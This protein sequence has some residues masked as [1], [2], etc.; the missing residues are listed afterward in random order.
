MTMDF[1]VM[2]QLLQ[3]NTIRSHA[4]VPTLGKRNVMDM[5]VMILIA[6]F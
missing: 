5:R 6:A 1:H 2:K 3:N 4:D